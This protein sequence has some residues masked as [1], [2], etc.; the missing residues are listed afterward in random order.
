MRQRPY[1]PEACP[2]SGHISAGGCF[3]RDEMQPLPKDAETGTEAE[4]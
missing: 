1:R 3:W 2:P 4:L